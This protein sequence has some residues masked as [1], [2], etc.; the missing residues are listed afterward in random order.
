MIMRWISDV[1]SKIV[2]ILA[3]A[4]TMRAAT[5]GSKPVHPISEEITLA[6]WRPVRTDPVRVSRLR[7]REPVPGALSP[8]ARRGVGSQ[9][10]TRPP[11]CAHADRHWH[12]HGGDD[13]GHASWC[14]R[15]ADDC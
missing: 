13:I 2:K 7:R 5:R 1:P 11:E 12:G 15:L 14:C 4:I 9:L 10:R 8:R 3:G 6:S